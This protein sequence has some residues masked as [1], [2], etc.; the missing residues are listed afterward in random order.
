VG[1]NPTRRTTNFYVTEGAMRALV[2]NAD[3]SFL[4]I[5][6]DW[7]RG[8]WLL[9]AGKVSSMWNYDKVVRFGDIEAEVPAVIVRK[10]YV[11]ARRRRLSFTLP[12]HKNIFI[13]DGEKCAYCGCKL[14][15]GTTTKDH[16]FPRSRGGKD[17]ILNVVAACTRCNAAKADKTP[18]EAG[19]KLRVEPRHLTN[20]EKLSVLLKYN[21]AEER[22]AWLSCMKAT[23]LTLF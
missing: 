12:T 6:P 5:T 23:G 10:D 13:R 21:T 17:D 8:S 20:E 3:Y 18:A 14:S 1:S 7:I 9:F 22:R 11:D 16:V 19:L 4:N 2:L 15:L